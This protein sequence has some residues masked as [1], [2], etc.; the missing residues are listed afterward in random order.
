MNR[1]ADRFAVEAP[2]AAAFVPCPLPV[3]VAA[4]P[5][6]VAQVAEIYR[7]AAEQTRCQLAPRRPAG[8]PA[9]SAN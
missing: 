8:L 5:L 9:F 4:G 6:A 1:I 7:L 3:L 2:V